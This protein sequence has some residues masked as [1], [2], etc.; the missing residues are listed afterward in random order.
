MEIVFSRKFQK[1]A[2]KLVENKGSLKK[3]IN[4]A[5]QDFSK[6]ARHA[7]C[8][9]KRLKGA[10]Y[11]YEEL[12]VGG[13]VRIIFRMKSNGDMAVLEQIGTHSQLGL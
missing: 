10:W 9:R 5:I 3:R 4:S 7:L 11:G 12:E 1:Q 13:D 6:N 2:K 8:Y